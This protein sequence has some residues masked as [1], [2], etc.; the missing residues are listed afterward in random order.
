[1]LNQR[2]QR[3]YAGLTG[4]VAAHRMKVAWARAFAIG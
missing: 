3:R 4:E 1:M 2:G